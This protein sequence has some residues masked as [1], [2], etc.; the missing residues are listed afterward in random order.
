VTAHAREF[1][2]YRKFRAR[3]AAKDPVEP[4]RDRAGYL[5]Y[6]D[7]GEARFRKLLADQQ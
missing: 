6:I 4:F 5:D 2:R 7:Q 1:G 3:D